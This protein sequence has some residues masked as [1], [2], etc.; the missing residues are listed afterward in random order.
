MKKIDDD[1][2][3]SLSSAKTSLIDDENIIVNLQESKETEEK[4]R[5]DIESSVAQMKKI[6]LARENYKELAKVASKLFF[7]INDFAL[8]DSM[9]QF[10]LDAYI[11]L[12]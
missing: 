11:G 8:I 9:Y 2:L 10:S 6:N 7:I 4:V 12:F 3:K 1:I 5:H